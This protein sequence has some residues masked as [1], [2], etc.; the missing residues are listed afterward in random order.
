MP[1]GFLAKGAIAYGQSYTQTIGTNPLPSASMAS[2]SPAA[3]YSQ[4]VP[5]SQSISPSS[6][7]IALPTQGTGGLS[8]SQFAGQNSGSNIV[9]QSLP[10]TTAGTNQY[11]NTNQTSS[12][13]Q[14]FFLLNPAFYEAI[15]SDIASTIGGLANWA[16]TPPGV[17]QGGAPLAGGQFPNNY[18]ITQAD[19]NVIQAS[20]WL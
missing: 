7:P 2:I 4:L 3:P 15:P 20:S 16:I 17:T 12:Q 13:N 10:I 6:I 18:L 9:G 19:I 1:S 11:T 8:Y 5:S 14:P